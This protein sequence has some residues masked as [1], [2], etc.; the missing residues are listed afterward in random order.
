MI[1][2]VVTMYILNILNLRVPG[3]MLIILLPVLFLGFKW[4]IFN[5]F[6]I[7][8]KQGSRQKPNINVKGMALAYPISLYLFSI[9]FFLIATYLKNGYIINN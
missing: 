6:K 7:D 5:V 8:K 1:S 3:L 2:L 9:M 4:L